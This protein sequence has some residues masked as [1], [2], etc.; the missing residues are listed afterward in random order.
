MV[1]KFFPNKKKLNIFLRINSPLKKLIRFY[2][3]T[4]NRLTI[5]LTVNTFYFVFNVNCYNF[6]YKVTTIIMTSKKINFDFGSV[7]VFDGFAIGEFNEGL[8]IKAEQSET[9]IKVC[10][11]YYKDKPFGYISNRTASYSID[12]TVYLKSKKIKNL[13]AIAVVVKNPAQI[14]SAKIEKIFF[15]RSFQYFGSLT[16]AVNW[17]RE[18][19]PAPDGN[20]TVRRHLTDL[21]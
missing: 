19:I 8:D 13:H 4:V 1:T 5:K 6:K 17:I 12:P 14:L 7:E 20:K 3:L 21:S 10:K 11:K 2:L 16:E 9:L 18:V 15:G